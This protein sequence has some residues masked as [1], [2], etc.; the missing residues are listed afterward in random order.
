MKTPS[1]PVKPSKVAFETFIRS[2][3]KDLG[4]HVEGVAIA[5]DELGAGLKVI[6]LRVKQ[7]PGIHQQEWR[8]QSAIHRAYLQNVRVGYYQPDAPGEPAMFQIDIIALA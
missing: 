6:D 4:L 5:D 7:V 1:K 3:A 8:L 2:V